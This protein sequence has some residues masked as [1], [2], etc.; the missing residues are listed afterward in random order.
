MFTTIVLIVVT[1]A[2]VATIILWQMEKTATIDE[3]NMVAQLRSTLTEK[4]QRID[5][6]QRERNALRGKLTLMVADARAASSLISG[7][8][9]E[10]D[11][12]AD[13]KG[14]SQ[15]SL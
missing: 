11:K 4:C 14:P 1:A 2:M 3:C 13:K 5:D 10:A 7:M 15:P 8:L 12:N 6:L 9:T